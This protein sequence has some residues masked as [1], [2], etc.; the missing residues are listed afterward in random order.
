MNISWSDFMPIWKVIGIMYILGITITIIKIWITRHFSKNDEPSS[1]KNLPYQ[2]RASVLTKAEKN[3]FAV[4]QEAAKDNFLILSKVRLA[5]ILTLPNNQ[6]YRAKYFNRITSK[7]VDFLLCDKDNSQPLLAIELDDSSHL[8][9]SRNERDI[10]VD[11][12]FQ[13]ANLPLLH[14]KNSSTYDKAELAQQIYSL[15]S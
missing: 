8:W 9:A 12:A 4:L 6:V 11:E 15:V 13:K 14:I 3:F 1:L 7:H 10:F 5:D 2:K